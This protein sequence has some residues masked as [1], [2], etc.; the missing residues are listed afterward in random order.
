MN[1]NSLSVVF[2]VSLLFFFLIGREIICWYW[3]VNKSIELQNAM[4]K[5]LKAINE[6]LQKQRL[7]KTG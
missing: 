1:D 4:I 7:G 5:E 3:K 2:L 6:E